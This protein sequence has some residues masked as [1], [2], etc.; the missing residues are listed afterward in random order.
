MSSPA[1]GFECMSKLRKLHKKREPEG[2][3]LFTFLVVITV[4]I[5]RTLRTG[6]ELDRGTSTVCA[7]RCTD[8]IFSLTSLYA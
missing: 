5:F 3:R 2:P 8:L 4:A 6:S 1:G 7:S